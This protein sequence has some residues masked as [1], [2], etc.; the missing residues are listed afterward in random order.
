MKHPALVDGI[1]HLKEAV[2][3]GLAPHV[4]VATEHAESAVTKLSKVK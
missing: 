2:A 1:A 3:H 4:N